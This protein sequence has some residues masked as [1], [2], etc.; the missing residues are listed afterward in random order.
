MPA[1]IENIGFIPYS[2]KS[3]DIVSDKYIE[4]LLRKI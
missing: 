2:I 1:V 4:E 3:K